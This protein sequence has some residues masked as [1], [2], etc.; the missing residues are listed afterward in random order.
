[1][2]ESDPKKHQ[3]L[4][5]PDF[6]QQVDRYADKF[7]VVAAHSD[8]INERI[9][10]ITGEVERRQ[11]AWYSRLLQNYFEDDPD[12]LATFIAFNAMFS[13]MPIL[14]ALA[15]I[16][17]LLFKTFGIFEDQ[18]AENF[19]TGTV[20]DPI[21]DPINEIMSQS[22]EGLVGIGLI[23]I[24]VLF[25]GGTRLYNSLDR[26]FAR[27]YLTPRRP[28]VTRKA[29]GMIM[30]PVLA[31]TIVIATLITSMILGL[32]F[33]PIDSWV[34]TDIGIQNYVLLVAS[35]YV[36]AFIMMMMAYTI[37]PVHR[38]G[39]RHALPGAAIAALALMLLSTIFPIYL[40]FFDTY[41]L[42]GAVFGFILTMMLWFYLASQIIVIGAEINAFREGRRP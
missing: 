8:H 30:V 3:D 24:V 33:L 26:A 15:V 36:L 20:P 38:P 12:G 31:L 25:W 16:I 28:W 34:E 39:F 2:N 5:I 7:D 6:T 1:M 23:T 29:V 42:Y 17:T 11:G 27:I 9:R 32:L 10:L 22:S 19:L 4:E 21:A 41:S 14:M 18:V 37:V 40:T 13:F 35:I